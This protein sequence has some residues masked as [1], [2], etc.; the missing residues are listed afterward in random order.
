MTVCLTVTKIL[1]HFEVVPAFIYMV[2]DSFSGDFQQQD[3]NVTNTD[4]SYLYQSNSR[5]T[6]WE[7][8]C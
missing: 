8:E 1:A 3:I 7:K 6:W 5:D 2:P 4:K